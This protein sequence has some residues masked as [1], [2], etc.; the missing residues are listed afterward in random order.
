MPRG[1]SARSCSHGRA[2]DDDAPAAAPGGQLG[3]L[4]AVPQVVH[5]LTAGARQSAGASAQWC[6][7][8]PHDARDG[9]AQVYS[10]PPAGAHQRGDV[11]R[12][13]TLAFRRRARLVLQQKASLR[14]AARQSGR[15]S[16]RAGVTSPPPG[17][18]ER[19]CGTHHAYQELRRQRRERRELRRLVVGAG[20]RHT[21]RTEADT[22]GDAPLAAVAGRRRAARRVVH[23]R[24]TAPLARRGA[25]AA[26]AG[27]SD[28]RAGHDRRWRSSRATR[29]ALRR[30][31]RSARERVELGCRSRAGALEGVGAHAKRAVA[32]AVA[33]DE[34]KRAVGDAAPFGKHRATRGAGKRPCAK[35]PCRARSR[36]RLVQK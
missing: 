13:A 31:Q 16:Q 23:A 20:V 3:Q 8:A 33:A 17:T 35:R 6:Q 10:K 32:R 36:C 5:L 26:S 2:R 22:A 12:R 7:H 9:H 27:G 21:P 19:K 14:G 29:R 1:E 30:G 18:R 25:G 11:L 24:A 34:A 15:A 28:K 4:G